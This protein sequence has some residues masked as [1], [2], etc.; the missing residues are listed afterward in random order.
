MSKYLKRNTHP[1]PQKQM[2]PNFTKNIFLVFFRFVCHTDSL[3]D[4]HCR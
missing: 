1:F 2:H 4:I 3:P